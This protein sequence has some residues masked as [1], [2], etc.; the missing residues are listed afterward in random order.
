MLKDLKNLIKNEGFVIITVALLASLLIYLLVKSPSIKTTTEIQL[1]GTEILDS[2]II[3]DTLSAD[4]VP[5]R[6]Q[7]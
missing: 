2:T 4:T 1:D 3:S 7:E 5:F 6:V